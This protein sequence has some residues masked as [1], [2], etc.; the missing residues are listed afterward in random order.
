MVVPRRTGAAE[1]L[2]VLLELVG[3][4]LALALVD[5]DGALDDGHGVVVAACGG[6]DGAGVLAEAAAA[7]ADARVQEA[8]ADA[9][10]E[11]D[12]AGDLGD[13]GADTLGEAGELVDEADLGGEEA[14]GRVLRELGA[15]GRGGD[16]AGQGVALGP[17][18]GGGWLEGLLEDGCVELAQHGDGLGLIAADDDAVGVEAV[19]HGATLG[20]EL[21]VAGDVDRRAHAALLETALD[22]GADVVGAADGDGALVDDG[23][24]GAVVDGAS[25]VAGGLVDVLEVGVAVGAGGGAD[26][27]EDDAAALEFGD[28]GADLDAVANLGQQLTEPVL[29]YRGLAGEQALDDALVDVDTGDGV[30]DVG[31]R[32]AGREAYVAG[33]DDGYVHNRLLVR[34]QVVWRPHHSDASPRPAAVSWPLGSTT[35]STSLMSVSTEPSVTLVVADVGAAVRLE[36]VPFIEHDA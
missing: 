36:S 4:V 5:V 13:V 17:R 34:R 33:A 31:E 22:D 8:G 29:E 10:V 1:D 25:D 21:G 26:G 28:G 20:E 18:R 30:A 3:D 19:V 15:G 32:E 6:D 14:V 24:F 2:E 27:D 35:A 16:E 23:E 12:G 11:A 9:F 7:P